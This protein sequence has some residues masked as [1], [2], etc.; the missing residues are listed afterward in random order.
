MSHLAPQEC[1]LAAQYTLGIA[2]I[3]VGVLALSSGCATATF[4]SSE[5][6]MISESMERVEALAVEILSD[7]AAR[8]SLRLRA[9]AA[10]EDPPTDAEKIW[11]AYYANRERGEFEKREDYSARLAALDAE[12]LF[13]FELEAGE[14]KAS[15]DID[16]TAMRVDLTFANCSIFLKELTGFSIAVLKDTVSEE[17]VGSNAYGAEIPFREVSG[18]EY[19]V[20]VND[21]GLFAGVSGLAIKQ[22]HGSDLELSHSFVVESDLAREVKASLRVELGL[23]L[24]GCDAAEEYTLSSS[25]RRDFPYAAFIQ[26]KYMAARLRSI[27]IHDGSRVWESFVTR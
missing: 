18:T 1:P 16:T 20:A 6:A 27:V 13:F 25:A 10:I 19:L 5:Q 21:L 23:S 11:D 24:Q 7:P 14:F 26:K 3:V 22:V 9:E 2:A 12:S 17:K 4:K 15:Y 8:T